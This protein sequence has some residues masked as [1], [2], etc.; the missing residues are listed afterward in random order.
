M[1]VEKWYLWQIWNYLTIIFRKFSSSINGRKK[2]LPL[3]GPRYTI[4]IA[5]PAVHAADR[6]WHAEGYVLPSTAHTTLLVPP[7]GKFGHRRRQAAQCGL[8]FWSRRQC[9]PIGH[10]ILEQDSGRKENVQGF[11]GCRNLFFIQIKQKNPSINTLSRKTRFQ[12]RAPRH[13]KPSYGMGRRS[14]APWRR[15]P[16]AARYTGRKGPPLWRR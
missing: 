10:W 16:G 7:S 13:C 15:V 8:R 4:G 3:Q 9:L 1:I 6:K 14:T 11:A 12:S 2:H 5:L